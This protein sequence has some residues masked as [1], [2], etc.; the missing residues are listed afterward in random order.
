MKNIK[1]ILI[2]LAVTS[3]VW[4]FKDYQKEKRNRIRSEFNYENL[5]SEK[6]SELS[7]YKLT[8]N[9]FKDY[10]DKTNNHLSKIKESLKQ[11]NIKLKKVSKVISTTY[12]YSDTTK[13]I[14][15]L[16]S[17]KAK[18]NSLSHFKIPFE[19]KDS[20]VSITGNFVYNNGVSDIVFAETKFNDT[21]NQ[22]VYW[23]RKKRKILFFK[24]GIGKKI[25]ETTTFSKCVTPKTIVIDIVKK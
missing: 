18:I 16:D 11:A 9:E 7:Q 20:C 13:Y 3:A 22:V 12:I 15:K 10:T 19:R 1:S 23:H 14:V 4:F 2:L 8:R 25:Y 24:I 17:L 5:L 6:E 21:I